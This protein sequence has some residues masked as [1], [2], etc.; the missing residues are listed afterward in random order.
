MMVYETAIFVTQNTLKYL[1]L[2][3][4]AEMHC[5]WTYVSSNRNDMLK[6]ERHQIKILVLCS[7]NFQYIWSESAKILIAHLKSH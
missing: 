4:L 6:S 3:N 1:Y 2:M 5:S 7:P